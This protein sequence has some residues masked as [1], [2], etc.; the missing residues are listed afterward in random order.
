MQG[1]R[2]S[3][4]DAHITL[5]ELGDELQHLALFCVFDGHG[6]RE[7]A[8]FCERHFTEALRLKVLSLRPTQSSRPS[9]VKPWQPTDVEEGG[10][11]VE[12]LGAD[13][14]PGLIGKAMG[15]TFLDMDRLLVQPE[16]EEELMS[17]KANAGGS[18]GQGSSSGSA[19]SGNAPLVQMQAKLQ[20]DIAQ[21]VDKAR[22]IGRL[23]SE[24]AARLAIKMS[25]AKRLE[26]LRPQDMP[27]G[28][29]KAADNVGCTAVCA[30]LAPS[31]IVVANA[32][33]SRAVLCRSGKPV[34]LSEDH[35]PNAERETKRIESAGG[36]IKE[37]KVKNPNGV[38]H[39][40]Y[41]VNGV[42]SLSRA[43]GDLRFKGVSGLTAAQQVIT[44]V[45]DIHI[46]PRTPQDE[47]IVL[48]C[49]GVWDVKSSAEV[50][51]FV[52]SRLRRGEPVQQVIEHLLDA[53]LA[54]DPRKTTGIGGDNMTCI[55]VVLPGL[56][57]AED[58]AAD[59]D[60]DHLNSVRRCSQ[61]RCLKNLF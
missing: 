53:C 21:D 55:V 2:L 54:K 25:F 5:H 23:S 52:R 20:N 1:W 44:A 14:G 34:P 9:G 35:K 58:V 38:E 10:G 36:F 12:D 46:E 8:R 28:G 33:D 29:E 6:G 16:S 27:S 60:E 11:E 26:G 41:R 48:A 15:E 43:I 22:T 24:E 49:D 31:H 17:L 45:P 50:C 18:N 3:M 4:E 42:L 40:T 61:M 57:S 30:V 13:L 32:G 37:V 56:A 51:T 39:T 47:F 19:A 7:V 59:Q